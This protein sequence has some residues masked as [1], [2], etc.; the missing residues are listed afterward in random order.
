MVMKTY[1]WLTVSAKSSSRRAA[2][3]LGVVALL[4]LPLSAADG[5]AA[6]GSVPS[7]YHASRGRALYSTHCG[8]CHQAN[9][10]GLSGVFPPLKGSGLVNRSDATKHIDIVLAGLQGAR[11]SGVTY[12]N[13]MP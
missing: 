4:A 13:P 11:A 6:P 8:A 5:L 9:G 12:T 3:V 2:A 1:R 7:D 10:E